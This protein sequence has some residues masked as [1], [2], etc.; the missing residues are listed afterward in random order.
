METTNILHSKWKSKTRIIFWSVLFISFSGVFSTIYDYLSYLLGIFLQMSKTMPEVVNSWGGSEMAD[1]DEDMMLGLGLSSKT[2]VAIGYV[3][4]LWG[5]TS[6]ASIQTL[7]TTTS[8]LRK[9]RN[10][11]ICLI[12]IFILDIVFGVLSIIPFTGWIFN[13]I[14]WLLSLLCFYKI[15]HAFGRLMTAE[16][17][18]TRA[19]RG[20]RN[21]RYAT[22]CEIRLKW[23]P[24]LL[25]IIFLLWGVIVFSIISS[26][27]NFEGAGTTLQVGGVVALIILAAAFIIALCALFCAFFWPIIGWYRIMTGNAVEPEAC[28]KEKSLSLSDTTSTKELDNISKEDIV[29]NVSSS[30][31]NVDLANNE[32][33]ARQQG[34]SQRDM[35]LVILLMLFMVAIVLFFIG[36]MKCC[37]A[38]VAASPNETV[39]VV[40]VIEDKVSEFT[41]FNYI[42]EEGEY[43]YDLYAVANGEKRAVDFAGGKLLKWD[44][45]IVI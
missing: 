39:E 41:G 23:L 40:S 35:V 31:D 1:F 25:G 28:N 17:F 2:I 9:V 29:P 10:A 21:L 7:R 38:A 43:G 11:V 14:I 24:L 36:R 13:I 34:I 5:L 33:Q 37:K 19:Q 12:L 42:V 32:K 22:A 16:D 30:T 15:K 45:H 4:Y 26:S 3:L 8:Q 44:E 18:N 27:N 20:A 6:F